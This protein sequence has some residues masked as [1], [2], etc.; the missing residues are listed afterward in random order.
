MYPTLSTLVSMR[1]RLQKEGIV[2]TIGN[3]K[4]KRIRKPRML[5][6]RRAIPYLSV[7]RV[8]CGDA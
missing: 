4:A 3:A 5:Y 1:T 8:F 2:S 7:N 6:Y